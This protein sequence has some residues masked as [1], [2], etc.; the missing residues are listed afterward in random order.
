MAKNKDNLLG[1]GGQRSTVS[2]S[3]LKGGRGGGVGGADRQARDHRQDL[4]RRIQER[5]ARAADQGA[6]GA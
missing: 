3:D 1:M 4:L 2:R 6:G 5:N